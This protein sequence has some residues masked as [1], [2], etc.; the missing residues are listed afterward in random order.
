MTADQAAPLMQFEIELSAKILTYIQDT[1]RGRVD[2]NRIAEYYDFKRKTVNLD[3]A[4]MVMK[5]SPDIAAYLE[6]RT[7]INP[8]V[9]GAAA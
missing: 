8:Q 1:V 4:L 9:R 2:P 5:R 7:P 6:S 3:G